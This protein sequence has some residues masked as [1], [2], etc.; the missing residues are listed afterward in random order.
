MI[1]VAILALFWGA[2]C[3]PALSS[4]PDAAK[5]TPHPSPPV[6]FK[7]LPWTNGETL[8]YLVSWTAFEA[9]EGTFV[10]TDKGSHWE[11]NLTL[12]SRGLVDSF[13]PFTGNF[14]SLVA[15]SPWRSTEYGEYRFEPRRVIK[16]RTQLDYAKHQ[17]TREIWSEGKTN[18][19]TIAEDAVDDLGTMLYHLRAGPWKPGDKRTLYVYESNSEKQ[20]EAECQGRETRA[21]GIW[22][23]QPL[24]RILALPTIGTHRRGHL[25]IWMTDDA[26]HLPLHAELQFRYGTFNIDLTK[27]DKLLPLEH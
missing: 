17:G 10:A 9:A 22:P 21:W 2:I 7:H 24:L 11:F 19:F 1:R 6:D 25:R 13:Y 5:P 8:T 3:P 20:A 18:T 14:W 16:E 15:S 12:A 26:R 4:V 23:A 27:A